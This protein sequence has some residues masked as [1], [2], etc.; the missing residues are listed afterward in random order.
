MAGGARNW[1]GTLQLEDDDWDAETWLESLVRDEKAKYVVGQ[2]ERGHETEH[3]HLQFYVQC[4]SQKNLVWMKRHIHDKAHW[5]TAKGTAK[6]NRAYCTKEDS[7]VRGPW[8]FGEIVQQGQREGLETAI[9]MVKEGAPLKDIALEQ[10]VVWVH[11]HRG[12]MDLRKQLGLEADRRVFGPEGPEVWCLWGPSG[13]GKSRWVNA[14]WPDA[15]WKIPN[16]KWW[17]GYTGQETII[18]DDYKDGDMR[19]SDLQRLLDWYP[20]WVEVKG[21]TIPMLAKRYVFTCNT[22]PSGWYRKAD[23]HRT[24]WRRFQEFAEAHGRLIMCE[25]GDWLERLEER[26][27]HF[28]GI[29]QTPEVGGNTSTPTPGVPHAVSVDS[30]DIA[31]PSPN[32]FF[33]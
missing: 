3:A 12:L 30:E 10:S 28:E 22:H 14:R 29:P 19:L 25:T 7:R 18:L 26:L 4:L 33:Y 16:E 15:F 1:C 8:E 11:H 9:K 20:L 17:D 24:I 5:E 6:H 23:P 13:T 21:G 32:D 2:I 31:I 27:E